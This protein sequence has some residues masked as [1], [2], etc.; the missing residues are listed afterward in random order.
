MNLDNICEFV[1]TD[2]KLFKCANC[3]LEIE[4]LEIQ[5]EMPIFVCSKQ[6][7]NNPEQLCSEEQIE[8]RYKI[9]SSCEFLENNSCMKCGCLLNRGRIYNNKLSH[10]NQVCPIGKWG[11]ISN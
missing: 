11:K 2:N 7:S 6:K 9:C 8:Q 1:T 10:K 4:A 3:G 5:M